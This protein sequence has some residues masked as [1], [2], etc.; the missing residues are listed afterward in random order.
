LEH[1][2]VVG[3]SVLGT[4]QAVP[5]ALLQWLPIAGQVTA[6]VHAAFGGLLQV[7]VNGTT[8]HAKLFGPTAGQLVPVVVAQCAD[9]AGQ[10]PGF[11]VQTA[12]GGLLQLPAAGQVLTPALIVHACPVLAHVPPLIGQSVSTLQEPLDAPWQRLRL[13][14]PLLAQLFPATLQVPLMNGQSASLVHTLPVLILQLPAKVGGGQVV[15]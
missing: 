4:V 15:V 10:D 12:L 13:Q 11:D 1:V 8:G 6:V 2:P 5:T 3:Q 9:M 7:P 14:S